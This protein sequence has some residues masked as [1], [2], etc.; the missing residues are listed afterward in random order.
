[1]T[2]ARSNVLVD[3]LAER[4]SAARDLLW[5]VGFTLLTALAAQVRI[6]LPFTPVP[7]TGQTFGVLLSGAL[8]GWRRGFGS[9]LLYLAAGAAGMPVFAGG[10]GMAY[11]LGPTAGYLWSF[12]IAAGLL[13]WLVER[14]ASRRAWTMA[15][16]MFV[17]SLLI[18]LAGTAW[19]GAGSGFGSRARWWAGFYP[20]LAGDILKIALVGLALPRVLW[21]YQT[22]PHPSAPSQ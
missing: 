13:G 22:R 9:Q 16:A 4:Q 17:C 10:G 15:S 11:L 21:Y 6:P 5:T 12:P 7:L 1:M 3:F 18:L 19:L 20:F 14:G 2:T 8:L